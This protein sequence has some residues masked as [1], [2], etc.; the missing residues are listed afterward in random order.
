M[1]ASYEKFEIEM[2]KNEAHIGYHSGDC[3]A[4]V[5][6]LLSLPKIKR[7][8]RKIN[9]DDLRTALRGYGAWSEEELNNRAD[10]EMRI[11]WDAACKIIDGG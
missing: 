4:G 3:E 7:Q 5:R 2:T 9:D 8:L 6:H 11:I 1:W 10:N